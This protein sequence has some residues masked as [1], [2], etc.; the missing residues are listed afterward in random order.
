MTRST[1]MDAGLFLLLQKAPNEEL[2]YG[3]VMDC[4]KNYKNPR[5]KLH[6]LL[7]IKALIRV[8]KGIYIFGKNFARRPYSSEVLANMIYGPSYLSLE[9]ACQHYRLIPER[10]FTTTSVTTQRSKSFT[11]PLGLFTYDHLPKQVF[12]IGVTLVKLSK[13]SQA[14][15]ATKEKALADLLV[16]RRGRIT[17]KKEFREILFE[18]LRVEEED[19][20]SFD[21][22]LLNTI[23]DARPHSAVH[24][25]IQC[26]T[27]ERCH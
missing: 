26:I 13:N 21:L 7:K 12:P 8:K 1:G 11:T 19:L 15:M 18:D 22:K 2:D 5:L 23:Y 3:F 9:W 16:L 6:H 17:S 25:L 20:Q 4:L 10:V 24:H 14:L 27:Y